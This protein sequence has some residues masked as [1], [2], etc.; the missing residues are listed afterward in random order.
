V[1]YKLRL[2]KRLHLLKK[3]INLANFHK[4]FDLISLNS[5]IKNHNREFK[6]IYSNITIHDG[7]IKYFGYLVFE[8]SKSIIH[9]TNIQIFTKYEDFNLIIPQVRYICI[10][11][12]TVI[13]F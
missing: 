4:D 9:E 8:K 10:Y 7:V 11:L 5:K 13:I 6:S 2:L 12:I 1:I 3:T